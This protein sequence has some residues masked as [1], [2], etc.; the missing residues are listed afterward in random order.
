MSDLIEEAIRVDA[1]DIHLT[2]GAPPILRVDSK[3]AVV[4]GQEVLT[5]EKVKELSFSLLNKEQEE[6]FW[7]YKDI[8]L[9]FSYGEKARFRVNIYQ[10]TGKIATALRLLPTKIRTIE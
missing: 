7:A 6:R 8:D 2:V 5:N 3:L 9:S 4:K 10:Q 1:T